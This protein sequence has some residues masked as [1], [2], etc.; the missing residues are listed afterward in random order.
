MEAIEPPRLSE[1]APLALLYHENSKINRATLPYLAESIGEFAADVE[2]LR[3]S[4]T[5]AKTYPGSDRIELAR[6]GRLPR[7]DQPLDVV[8]AGRRS[9]REFS[10]APVPLRAVASLLQRALGVTGEM[11]HAEHPEIRQRMRAHP[12]GG[13]LYPIETYLVALRVEQLDAGVYHYH[14]PDEC[15]EVVRRANLTDRLASLV[16]TAGGPFDAAGVIVLA[17]RWE[18]SIAKYGERSYRVVLLDAGHV[19]QNLLLVATGLGLA[20]CPVA[21]FHDDALAAEVGLDPN[22]EPVLYLILFG[23]AK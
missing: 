9:V 2:Q 21:G 8:L 6:L 7:P 22:R 1:L 23:G 11:T 16:L 20:T 12:S 17:A 13:A 5:A 4:A 14:A 19:A 10:A 3:R 15:L 18:Q